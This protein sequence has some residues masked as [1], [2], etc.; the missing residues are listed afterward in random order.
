[1]STARS[2]ITAGEHRMLKLSAIYVPIAVVAS[3]AAAIAWGAWTLSQE[4]SRIDGRID[5]LSI[6]VNTISSSVERLAAALEGRTMDRYS[7]E[8]ALIVCLSSQIVNGVRCTHP[9]APRYIG[10]M[11]TAGAPRP[12]G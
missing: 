9:D 3:V 11:V 2:A 6:S 8:D 4:R 7:R 1:M 12:A 5:E 10:Q